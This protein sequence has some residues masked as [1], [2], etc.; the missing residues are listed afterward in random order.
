MEP[1]TKGR[2]KSTVSSRCRDISAP[3]GCS[4][5]EVIRRR[6]TRGRSKTGN[7]KDTLP[8]ADPSAQLL[9]AG[10]LGCVLCKQAPCSPDSAS[11]ALRKH[12]DSTRKAARSVGGAG[13]RGNH[14]GL[15]HPSTW[16]VGLSEPVGPV[17][18]HTSN[19]PLPQTGFREGTGKDQAPWLHPPPPASALGI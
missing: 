5:L 4:A 13:S 18:W 9:L 16:G 14:K 11:H 15:T 8:S 6:R 2:P 10:P 12:S 3:K 17:P 19:S 1:T 7:N